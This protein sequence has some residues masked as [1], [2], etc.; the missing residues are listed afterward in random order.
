MRA[1][2]TANLA[3]KFMLELAAFAAF[4]YWGA[5]VGWSGFVSILFAIAAAGA[6]ILLWARFAAPRSS[7]RLPMA[8]RVPFELS[9][10]G[11]AAAALAAAVDLRATLVFLLA[12]VVN[13][14]LLTV[15]HQWGD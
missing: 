4:A 12:A 9:V 2:K 14:A 8:T 5:T 1:V 13:T 7:R 10:F 15:F 11:L 6:A 3:L